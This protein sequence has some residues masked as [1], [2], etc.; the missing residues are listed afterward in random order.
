MKNR[1]RCIETF[2]HELRAVSIWIN[3]SVYHKN[4]RVTRLPA[5]VFCWEEAFQA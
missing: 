1:K 5:E 3:H 4:V 2:R